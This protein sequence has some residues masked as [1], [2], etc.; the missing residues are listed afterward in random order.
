MNQMF[1]TLYRSIVAATL[2]VVAAIGLNSCSLINDDLKPC[3]EGV[4]LRFVYDYNMEFANAFPAQVDCLT[5]LVYDNNGNY[6]KTITET[7]SVLADEN[8]RMT[9]DL[10]AGKT[11]HFV[12]YGGLACDKAS[13]HFVDTPAQGAKLSDLEVAMNTDCVDAD[14]GV[15]LHK[16]FFGA[17]DL[18]VPAGATDYTQ[19]TVYMLRDT[20]TIRIML[21]NVDGT[22]VNPADFNFQ[23]TANNT[24]MAY[25]NDLIPTAAGNTYAPWVTGQSVTGSV[26]NGDQAAVAFAEFSVARLIEN[27]AVRLNITNA[28]QHENV[29]S[30]PLIK[31]LLLCKSNVFSSMADQE[32]LDRENHWNII[33]F[34]NNGRWIDTHIVVNDWIVRINEE[35]L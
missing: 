18:A 24:L 17:L 7:S 13:F 30:I 4:V 3:P 15:E 32:Y 11:Y 12:A 1:K 29:L 34:M 16:L 27:E 31:Y 5:L 6:I 28:V 33:L 20:N 2:C 8:W 10:P 14:P 25:N 9:I 19:G 22:V 35:D 21:Q 23:I 26:D